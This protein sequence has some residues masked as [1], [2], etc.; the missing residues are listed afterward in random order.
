MNRLQA[1]RWMMPAA[2]VLALVIASAASLHA[3]TSSGESA[4]QGGD[5]LD[6]KLLEG[7]GG[8]DDELLEGLEDD[9]EM[10]SD[11]G[12]DDEA[13]GAHTGSDADPIVRLGRRMR[14]VETLIA[15]AKSDDKTQQL[16]QEI[17]GDLEKLIKELQRRQQQQAASQS[18]RPQQT[19]GREKV[20]Q[21]DAASG[22]GGNT[23][24]DAAARDSSEKLREEQ[25]RKA[26]LAE[27]QHQLKDI[28]GQLPE[29]MR[30]QMEQGF[31]EQFL[32][33]YA[34]QIEEYFKSLIR[35]QSR[36]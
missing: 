34:L 16:Q 21:P 4:K 28:W 19:T 35:Q 20:E 22:G 14:Q 8:L 2:L 33:K 29:R 26:R 7:L 36:P 17:V 15:G 10:P 1:Y 13:D 27:T 25:A 9:D 11:A 6:D 32:P 5:S 3:Q 12:P 23:P 31:G 30:E 24:A 18:K